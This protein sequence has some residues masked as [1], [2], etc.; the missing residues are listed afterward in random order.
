[1][2]NRLHAHLPIA[3]SL[4]AWPYSVLTTLAPAAQAK[5]PS[6]DEELVREFYVNLTSSE[7]TEVPVRRIKVLITSNTIN[8]FFELPDF[9]NDD[10]SSLMSNIEPENLQEIL[11]ELT[12]LGSKWTVSKQGIHT[13]RREYLTPLTKVWFYFSCFNL[14]PSSHGTTISLE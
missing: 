8:E 5:R 3:P 10:Y 14:M 11:K 13:C 7:L 9:E 12:V 2:P 4:P 1:M 6:V